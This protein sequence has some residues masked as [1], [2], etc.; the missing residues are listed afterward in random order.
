MNTLRLP[1]LKI[2]IYFLLCPAA[3]MNGQVDSLKHHMDKFFIRT[4]GT[5]ENGNKRKKTT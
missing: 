3:A 5:K 1:Q 4:K 2:V